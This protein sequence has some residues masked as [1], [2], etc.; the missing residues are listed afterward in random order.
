MNSLKILDI[1][2]GGKCNLACFQCDTRSD[3]IRTD[4]YDRDTESILN[5]INLVQKHFKI[6]TYS[7][8]GGE[9]LLYLSQIIKIVKHI[10]ETDPTAKIIIPTNGTL[11]HKHKEDL[12]NLLFNYDVSLFVCNHF[13]GFNDL[14]LSTKVISSALQFCKDLNL[15]QGNVVEFNKQLSGRDIL[16]STNF[17]GEEYVYTNGNINVWIR[18]QKEFHS[19]Y[20]VSETGPKPFMSGNPSESYKEGC[21]SP[22]CSFLYD[23]KLY[24]CAALGTLQ[25]FL[26]FHN[27]LEDA[28]WQ[29]YLSYKPLNLNTASVEEI[30]D[31]SD[32]KFSAKPECDMCPSS[33][34]HIFVKNESKVIKFFKEL[35]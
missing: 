19:H 26:K 33:S 22:M 13:A 12:R 9:P 1:Y 32:S 25:R 24:K 28:D 7:M 4:E 15:T 6:E 34:D 31:F 3:V 35:S 11:L 18:N 17:L 29:K 30:K 16:D 27:L 5:D 8:L 23:G 14:S 20:Y 21:C 10:K 2:I